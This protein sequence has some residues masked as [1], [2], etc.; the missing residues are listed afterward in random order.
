LYNF[1][2]DK[3]V[4][5]NELDI[6]LKNL[7]T[8]TIKQIR[9]ISNYCLLQ[10]IPKTDDSFKYEMIR[11]NNQTYIS[12]SVS[13]KLL[14]IIDING[15]TVTEPNINKHG[16]MVSLILDKTSFYCKAGGQQN[17]IGLIKTNSGKIFN[18][19]NVEKIQ[20]NGIVLHYIKSSDWPMLL[21]YIYILYI[22][23]YS[24]VNYF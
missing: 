17:D 4:N 18:V 21:R 3:V 24:F 15:N 10:D 14:A 9:K 16:I 11:H 19:I 6:N 5:W 20:E 8:K 13:A 23:Y 22:N 2:S 7:Q 1:F 12:P